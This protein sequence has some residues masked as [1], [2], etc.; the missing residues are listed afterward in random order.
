MKA[1][2]LKN[3]L[4]T[5]FGVLAGLPTI[6]LGSGIVLDPR[7]THYLMIAAGVGTVGLGVVAK[8]FNNHSTADQVQAATQVAKVESGPKA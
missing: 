3:Y 4:T 1:A 5:F 6:V 8:A 2:V 7:W